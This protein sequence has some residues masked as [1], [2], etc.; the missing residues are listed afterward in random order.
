MYFSSEIFLNMRRGILYLQVAMF[1]LLYEHHW[2][3][4]PF[5]LNIFLTAK[6]A[7][8]HV[9]IKQQWSWLTHMWR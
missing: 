2:N 1:Y 3:T 7:I 8:Y 6:G 9:A 5:H 4:K